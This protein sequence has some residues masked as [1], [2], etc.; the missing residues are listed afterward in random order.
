MYTPQSQWIGNTEP[1]PPP[2]P[3]AAKPIRQRP[4]SRS[5]ITK[6]LTGRPWLRAVEISEALGVLCTTPDQ[7][8][9]AE[10]TMR[11]MFQ[12]GVVLRKRSEFGALVFGVTKEV[13]F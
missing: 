2:G 7:V 4:L 8:K 5:N 13:P 1:M 9:G 12:A 6:L 3:E 10:R 11:R